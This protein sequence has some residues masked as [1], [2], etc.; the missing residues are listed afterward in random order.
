MNIINQKDLIEHIEG[1][2]ELLRDAFELFTDE[3]TTMKAELQAAIDSNDVDAARSAAHSIK[4][5]LSNF[6]AESACETAGQI[7]EIASGQ[8]LEGIPQ[9]SQQLSEQMNQDETELSQMLDSAGR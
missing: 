7:Q 9:L 1:D 8:T 6:L 3:K 5:M 2:L 4:G